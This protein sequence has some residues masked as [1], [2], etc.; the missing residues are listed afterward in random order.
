MIIDKFNVHLRFICVA[1]LYSAMI[2]C[3]KRPDCLLGHRYIW[4]M[5]QCLKGFCPIDVFIWQRSDTLMDFRI[6]AHSQQS[7]QRFN[8]C[9]VTHEFCGSPQ[10]YFLGLCDTD[11]STMPLWRGQFSPKLSQN[12]SHSSPVRA[13]YGMYFVGSNSGSCF[14]S[15]TTVMYA[16]SHYIGPRYNGTRHCYFNIRH[17]VIIIYQSL[18][19]H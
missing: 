9:Q 18:T 15:V 19:N 3:I 1:L 6:N 11:Y 12:T 4:H 14:A 16:I 10:E 8:K 17:I 2:G 5:C 7:P 13:R